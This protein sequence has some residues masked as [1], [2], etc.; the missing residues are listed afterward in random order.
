MT[1]SETECVRKCLTTH[2]CLAVTVAAYDAIACSLVTGPSD[3]L[4]DVGASIYILG[5]SRTI[6]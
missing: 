2:A 3:V 6:H 4:H 5:E 1:S